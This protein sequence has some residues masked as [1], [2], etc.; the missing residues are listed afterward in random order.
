MGEYTDR[1]MI[2]LIAGGGLGTFIVAWFGGFIVA[3]TGG[4]VENLGL[5]VLVLLFVG[6]LIGIWHELNSIDAEQQ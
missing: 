6:V 2:L 1:L 5:A 3:G 4:W